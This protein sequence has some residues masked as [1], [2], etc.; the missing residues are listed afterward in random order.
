MRSA[1]SAS[2]LAIRKTLP[3]P[4]EN[5]RT[6]YEKAAIPTRRSMNCAAT[7]RCRRI[8]PATR[9]GTNT[10]NSDAV[11]GSLYAP[12]RRWYTST[13][14]ETEWQVTT[15]K[16]IGTSNWGAANAMVEVVSVART[17]STAGNAYLTTP[18]STIFPVTASV[19]SASGIAPA[20]ALCA[21]SMPSAETYVKATA[22]RTTAAN[23]PVPLT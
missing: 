9:V 3:N 8:G 14:Y 10:R 21:R 12:A 6:P 23:V 19:R 15:T 7:S 18:S 11:S 13:R 4:T 1:G 22:A 5:R 2:V 16:P 17:P 20:S